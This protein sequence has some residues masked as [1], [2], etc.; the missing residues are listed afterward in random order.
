MPWWRKHFQC[1]SPSA[2]RIT[3]TYGA[4]FVL[5]TVFSFLTWKM[6]RNTSGRLEELEEAERT[7]R[8]S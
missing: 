7:G 2:A 3:G 6:L 5:G 1:W 4:F 8:P